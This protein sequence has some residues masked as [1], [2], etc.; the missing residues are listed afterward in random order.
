MVKLQYN[1]VNDRTILMLAVVKYLKK[2]K[3]VLMKV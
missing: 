1:D 3:S 2:K